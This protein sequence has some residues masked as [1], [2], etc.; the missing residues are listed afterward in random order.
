VAGRAERA[1]RRVLLRL[2]AGRVLLQRL[3]QLLRRLLQVLGCVL[4]RALG[5]LRLALAELLLGLLPLPLGL[6]HVLPGT[7]LR[8]RVVGLL[9]LAQCLHRLLR[10]PVQR[11][12]GLVLGLA[13]LV[14]VA[15]RLLVGRLLHLLR[16][17]LRRAGR[18][19]DAVLALLRLRLLRQLLQL[20]LQLL[21]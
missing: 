6:L 12:G 13:H 1:G 14:L 19:A 2:G 20:L 21:R 9:L 17:L 4:H 10:G 15:R 18:V 8:R 11:L 5:V 3:G 16:R 7:L